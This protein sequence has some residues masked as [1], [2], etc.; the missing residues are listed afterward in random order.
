MR[1]IS[2]CP[3]S[4]GIEIAENLADLGR[5]DLWPLESGP[6]GSRWLLESCLRVLRLA[7]HGDRRMYAGDVRELA[8]WSRR[9]GQWRV[10]HHGRD[11]FAD[12]RDRLEDL[13]DRLA[14]TLPESI[15]LDV[16]PEG[17][18]ELIRAAREARGLTQAQ[19]G[20]L[21]S[22]SFETVSRWERG[23]LAPRRGHRIALAQVLGG[24]AFDYEE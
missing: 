13:L 9:G 23:V 12:M 3:D 5:L 10:E 17:V 18:G 1:S 20:A 15:S 7:L 4:L 24:T 11:V 19:L 14:A 6:P 16:V 8:E 22:V 2:D 21:V